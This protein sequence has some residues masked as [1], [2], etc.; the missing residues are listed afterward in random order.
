MLLAA[1]LELPGE[2]MGGRGQPGVG[3]AAADGAGWPWKLSAA[4][5]SSMVI[6]DGSGS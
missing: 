4:M 2:P 6:S 3:V 1:E 5:A